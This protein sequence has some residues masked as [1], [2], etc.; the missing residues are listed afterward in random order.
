MSRKFFD[1]DLERCVGCYACVVACMDQNDLD[2]TKGDFKW[3]DVTSLF[4]KGRLKYA[5][6]SCMH[7]SDAPC[8][9]TCPTGAVFKNEESGFVETDET[10][11][12]GCRS[13]AMNCPF[14]IPKF[15]DEGKMEKCNGCSVRV[16]HG[17]E[18]AC[19]RTCPTRAL[20]YDVAG[21]V[22][23]ERKLKSLKKA[24]NL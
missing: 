6:L 5:S 17:Y 4:Y 14:G 15:G 3:R 19:A 1:L 8:V 22:E 13:C 10:K 20:K 9:V 12:I 16:A 21:D 11:C 18:P 7:C 23:K 24:L 2:P